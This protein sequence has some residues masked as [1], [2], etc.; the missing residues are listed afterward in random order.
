[1][2]NLILSIMLLMGFSTAQALEFKSFNFNDESACAEQLGQQPVSL[3]YDII[4]VNHLSKSKEICLQAY[5][6]DNA[7]R[8]EYHRQK[9]ALGLTS[10][11][12]SNHSAEQEKQAQQQCGGWLKQ[13]RS[14][15]ESFLQ[16]ASSVCYQISSCEADADGDGSNYQGGCE[17]NLPNGY[18]SIDYDNGTFEGNWKNGKRH[19]QGVYAWASGDRYEGNWKNDKKHGQ[20]VF[21]WAS[22]S[23]YEG[24]WKNDKQH[25][26]GVYAWASGDR[27]EGNWKNDKQH[28]QG[29]YAWASGDRYEGNHKNSKQHGQGTYYY[30]DGDTKS[31]NWVNDKCPNCSKSW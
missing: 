3:P 10:G 4:N 19:G 24:N 18:G 25:G 15:C 28:G 7:C 5:T 6:G 20:G 27:Y 31:G 11:I 14:A 17:N 8:K 23:R 2:K 30:S 26:Q 9:D 16:Q 12:R 1:M 21:T 29:V 13:R 22:G